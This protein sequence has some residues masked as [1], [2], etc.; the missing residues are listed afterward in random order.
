MFNACN[1]QDRIDLEQV[2]FN[3]DISPLLKVE[4]Y[5][6]EK[7]TVGWKPGYWIYDIEKFCFGNFLFS[8]GGESGP[9]DIPKSKIDLTMD[10]ARTRLIAVSIIIEKSDEAR[11]FLDYVHNKYG[12][13]ITLK[14]DPKPNHNSDIMGHSAELWK[15]IAPGRSLIL[16]KDY[17]EKDRKPAF[18]VILYIVKS[19]DPEI[20]VIDYDGNKMNAL[21]CLILRYAYSHDYATVKKFLKEE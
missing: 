18:S 6:E 1:S 15:D 20:F 16:S 12:K 9:N 13:P 21:E 8:S 19:D 2:D 5:F 11:N 17:S 4:K 10:S 3:A 7:S 14:E